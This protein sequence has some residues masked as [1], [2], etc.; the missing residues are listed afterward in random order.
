MGW[1]GGM[2]LV[3]C[4]G[5]SMMEDGLFLWMRIKAGISLQIILTVYMPKYS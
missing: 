1:G 3:V 5:L 2:V 4:R